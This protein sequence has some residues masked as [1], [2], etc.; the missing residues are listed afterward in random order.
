MTG[1]SNDLWSYCK[2]SALLDSAADILSINIS[3]NER[4]RWSLYDCPILFLKSLFL[5][6]QAWWNEQL[7]I[8]PFDWYK[9]NGNE[10]KW[11]ISDLIG[12]HVCQLDM[13]NSTRSSIFS[14]F[15]IELSR[16]TCFP[17]AC[18]G[19]RRLW[20]WGWWLSKIAKISKSIWYIF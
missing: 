12:S 18:Q 9:N 17:T 16:V 15:L 1:Y 10:Q 2:L 13:C 4:Q 20:V 19:K 11:N 6:A 14:D 5:I 3:P 7:S 8:V